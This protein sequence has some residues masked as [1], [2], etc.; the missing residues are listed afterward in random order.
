M[1]KLQ[2]VGLSEATSETTGKDASPVALSV[3]FNYSDHSF[4]TFGC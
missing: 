2:S 1:G 3:A 4:K